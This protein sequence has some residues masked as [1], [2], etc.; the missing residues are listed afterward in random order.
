MFN[1]PKERWYRLLVFIRVWFLATS[2]HLRP[3]LER[4]SSCRVR[5]T[6]WRTWVSNKASSHPWLPLSVGVLTLHSCDKLSICSFSFPRSP[7]FQSHFVLWVL[8]PRLPPPIYSFI[9]SLTLQSRR[10]L[11]PS[12]PPRLT[13]FISILLGELRVLIS[14]RSPLHIFICWR[15]WTI[16]C[17]SQNWP[18]G[19]AEWMVGDSVLILLIWIRSA[20]SLITKIFLHVGALASNSGSAVCSIMFSSAAL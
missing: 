18:E 6:R 19:C 20:L 10:A 1:S 7:H 11:P 17:A 15:D 14:H 4:E 3:R 5:A 9:W 16:G 8:S 13:A 12:P 2:A